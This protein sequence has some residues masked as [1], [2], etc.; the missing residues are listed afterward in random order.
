MLSFIGGQVYLFHCLT[1]LDAYIAK[2][3]TQKSTYTYDDSC[4]YSLLDIDDDFG[5]ED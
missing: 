2:R 1:K 5:E 4:R 3:E